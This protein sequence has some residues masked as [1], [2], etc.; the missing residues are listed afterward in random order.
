MSVKWYAHIT[1]TTTAN[2]K[3]ANDTM[4]PSAS[5]YH[6]MITFM[7]ACY[8]GGLWVVKA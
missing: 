2:D 5:A 1:A 8:Y 4:K 7:Q 3:A 6:E